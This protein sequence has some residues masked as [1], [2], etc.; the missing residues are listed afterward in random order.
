MD[1]K[2][3]TRITTNVIKPFSPLSFLLS[4]LKKILFRYN[5]LLSIYE[6]LFHMKQVIFHFQK[7]SN[8]IFNMVYRSINVN[9]YFVLNE[10]QKCKRHLADKLH[11]QLKN[12]CKVMD[13]IVNNVPNHVFL[14]TKMLTFVNF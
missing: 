5:I 2:T 10:L 3:L 11:K 9:G 7:W 6:K 1:G 14:M 12:I 8:C 4:S 13:N